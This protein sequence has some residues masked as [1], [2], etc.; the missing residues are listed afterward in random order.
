MLAEQSTGGIR[1]M[2]AAGLAQCRVLLSVR[3]RPDDPSI[4]VGQRKRCHIH[5]SPLE[6]PAQPTLNLVHLVAYATCALW[7]W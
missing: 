7:P 6:Q 5:V 2:S 3:E 1:A 4:L